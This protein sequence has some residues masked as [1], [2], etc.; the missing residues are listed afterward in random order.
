MGFL[1]YSLELKNNIFENI[2]KQKEKDYA[3]K[4]INRFEKEKLPVKVKFMLP[5][6]PLR[7]FY[8]VFC[9]VNKKF[10]TVVL[11]A[12]K[13]NDLIIYIRLENRK[14]LDGLSKFTENIRSQILNARDC[15]IPDTAGCEGGVYV[16]TFNNFIYKKC[17][18]ISCNFK[19]CNITKN[20]FVN[21]MDIINSEISYRYNN[22]C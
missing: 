22:Q 7:S 17:T 5:N 19:F 15:N 3:H 8:R 13:D 6:K 4:I 1:P 10:A 2:N 20:D 9:F 16:F 12:K 14:I 11:D 18:S 21:I